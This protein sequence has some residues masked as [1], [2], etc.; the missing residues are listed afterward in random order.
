MFELYNIYCT[1]A[2]GTIR[3]GGKPF[4]SSLK[5]LSSRSLDISFKDDITVLLLLNFTFVSTIDISN[6]IMSPLHVPQ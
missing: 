2:E 3:G 4:M 1:T 6:Q 5:Y